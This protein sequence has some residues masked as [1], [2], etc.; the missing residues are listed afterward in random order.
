MF[1]RGK[2]VEWF[3]KKQRKF[4]DD[5]K[6]RYPD[7]ESYLSY[8]VLVGSSPLDAIEKLDFP[9]PYSARTFL[10]KLIKELSEKD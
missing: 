7:F 6:G 9:E 5:I 10:E 4:R 3:L 1:G 8:H 2:R